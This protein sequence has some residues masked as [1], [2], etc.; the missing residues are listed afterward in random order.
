MFLDFKE[1]EK[2]YQVIPWLPPEDFN[3]GLKEMFEFF[4]DEA[5][6]GR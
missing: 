1:T 3:K 6:E 5:L 2:S 4:M